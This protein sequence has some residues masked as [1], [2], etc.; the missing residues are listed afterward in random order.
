M[1]I[2]RL[3]IKAILFLVVHLTIF[4]ITNAQQPD[5]IH[6][7]IIDGDL[8]KV[9]ERIEADPALLELK[10]DN[11]NTPLISACLNRQVEVAN[12]LIDK[13]ADVKARGRFNFTTLAWASRVHDQDTAIIRRLID[14]GAD[15]NAQ[16]PLHWAALEGCYQVAKL[17]IDN[18][19]NVNAVGNNG[20]TPLHRAA[21]GGYLDVAKLLIEHGADVNSFDKYNGSVGTFDIAG[22]IM[23]IAISFCSDEEIV[24]LLLGSGAKLNNTE[25][26]SAAAK[27]DAEL[28][29][30]FVEYGVD[31]NAVDKKGHTALYYAAK[32]GYKSVAEVLIAAGADESAIVETNYG[33]A[34]QL[35]ETLQEGEAYLWNVGHGYVV[36]TKGNLLI[37]MP[38]RINESK[39]AGL[40][41]GNL[42]PNELAGQ[43]ITVFA[44][45]PYHVGRSD[46]RRIPDPL[47]FELAK[48]IPETNWVF[49]SKPSG[50]NVNKLG[51]QSYYEPVPNESFTFNGIQV[52]TIPALPGGMGYLVETDGIKIFFAGYHVS[53]N[54]AENIKKYRK[55]IDFLK[56]FGPIDI[57][58]ISVC[59]HS[60]HIGYS[61]EPH[62]YMLNQLSPKVI[63]LFA[64][65]NSQSYF[66]C[67][68]VLGERNIS[69]VY[70]EREGERFHYIRK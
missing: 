30:L 52:H 11:G 6:K 59:S 2:N 47:R 66:K 25:L 33:K 10:D 62:L 35:K 42:N 1:K 61:D 70:P 39:E 43:N 36:K 64:A 12:F 28:T 56:P 69:I 4:Q 17:L 34:P 5:D 55:E 8:N 20:V 58:V 48:R 18:G 37:S 22:R 14:E 46:N 19:A 68:D 54:K 23:D 31:F 21:Q 29:K 41:N 7:V 9:K 65:N 38:I 13:G 49:D 60:S 57:A 67:V 26:H 40:A 51:I 3:T 53:D 45:H 24:K 15:V 63:Y 44:S 32:Y 16:S 27:G 50:S